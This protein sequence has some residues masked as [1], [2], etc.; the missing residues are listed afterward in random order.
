MIC[1]LLRTAMADFNACKTTLDGARIATHCLYPSF[2]AVHVYIVK[3]GE[4]FIVHDGKG[5]FHASWEHGR[6]ERA[7][8]RAINHEAARYQLAVEDHKLVANNV[9][10]DWLKSAILAVANASAAAAN[11]IVA[12]AI[13]AADEELVTKIDRVLTRRI[14]PKRIARNFRLKGSSGGDR[15]FDFAI[16]GP[17]GYELFLNGVTSHHASY[18]AKYV[19]FSDLETDLSNK[20][21]IRDKPLKT[22]VESLMLKVS[23]VVPLTAIDDSKIREYSIDG[24]KNTA[25]M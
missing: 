20:I 23:T 14:A 24:D 11:S 13:A 25:Y 15:H 21:S 9:P 6:D 3:D 2:E 5:A 12:K 19:A 8:S 7:I 1:E 18:S 17:E 22:D 10:M 4:T 16:R